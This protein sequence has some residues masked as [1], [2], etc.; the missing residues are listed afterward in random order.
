MLLFSIEVR[1]LL[2]LVFKFNRKGFL[3]LASSILVYSIPAAEGKALLSAVTWAKAAIKC[4]LLPV[5]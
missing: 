3:T 1:N 4:S 2:V 5:I